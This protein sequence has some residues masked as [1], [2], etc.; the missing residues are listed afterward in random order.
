MQNLPEINH[1]S[2]NLKAYWCATCKAHTTFRTNWEWSGE[3]ETLKYYCKA[4]RFESLEIFRPAD[5]SRWGQLLRVGSVFSFIIA[6]ICFYYGDSPISNLVFWSATLIGVLS[7]V[8]AWWMLHCTKKWNVWRSAQRRKSPEQLKQEA[9]N[10][11][12]Q[13]E[14]E[15]SGDFTAWAEQFLAPEEVEQLHVKYERAN[16]YSD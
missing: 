14:Y 12:F 1:C 5:F 4:H 10:H 8:P 7:A 13:P 3:D 11:P 9:M 16:V 6:Y 15:S 2:P